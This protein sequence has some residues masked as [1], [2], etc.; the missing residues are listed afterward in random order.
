MIRNRTARHQRG[1]QFIQL[2]LLRQPPVPQ[3]IDDFLERRV[4]GQRLDSEA[5]IAE[6]PR[7][8]VDKTQ[9]RFRRDDSL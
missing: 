8:A 1:L 7:V 6:Q 9:P 4:L 3:Q 5:L 2:G